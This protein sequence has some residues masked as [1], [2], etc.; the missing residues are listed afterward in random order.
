MIEMLE[1]WIFMGLAFGANA[2]LAAF[3]ITYREYQ[4]HMAYRV[5]PIRYALSSALFAFLFFF[6]SALIVGYA[7]SRSLTY[8]Y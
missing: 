7:I 5:S 8:Q 3:L 6:V 4:D 1:L 2:V